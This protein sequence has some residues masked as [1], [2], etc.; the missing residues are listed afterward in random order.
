MLIQAMTFS[1][2][3]ISFAD[4]ME[5]LAVTSVS[6]KKNDKASFLICYFAN[7]GMTVNVSNDTNC[8]T[9]CI[10]YDMAFDKR[11]YIPKCF[12]VILGLQQWGAITARWPYWSWII[13]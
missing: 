5:F 3:S 11:C 7:G 13:S 12:V 4:L 8:K 6:I 1:R 9:S 2:K 10:I